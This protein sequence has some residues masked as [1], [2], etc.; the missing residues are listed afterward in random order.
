MKNVYTLILFFAI[1]LSQ[2]SCAPSGQRLEG[3][4][5]NGQ[6]LQMFLD[7]VVMGKANTVVGKTDLD[8]AGNFV[9]TFE[10]PIIPGIYN[11]RIGAKKVNLFFDGTERNVVLNGD[12]NTLQE[13]NFSVQGSP[14][15]NILVQMMNG[16]VHRQFNSDDIEHFIDTVSNPLLGAFISYKALGGNMDFLDLQKNALA[17]LTAQFPNDENTIEYGNYLAQAERQQVAQMAMEK[18]RIGQPAPNIKLASPTGKEYSLTDLKG[19]V[20][21]LDFWASW[22]GPCRRENPNVVKVYEKYKDQGFTVFSVSLDGVDSRSRNSVQSDQIKQMLEQSKNRWVNAISQDGLAW[23]Y[24]VSDLLKWESLPA[25]EYGV[26]SIPRTFMIDREGKIAALNLRGAQ[27]IERELLKILE[28]E[29]AL[30]G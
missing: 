4:M 14:T 19:K 23:E 9:L 29:E 8:N 16:L 15:S 10:E 25:A 3:T 5:A 6:N 26:R 17:K 24:H 30:K 11:F 22:C 21:L 2:W 1:A 28:K 27:H 20:V 7:R 18:V 13:Y 12:L